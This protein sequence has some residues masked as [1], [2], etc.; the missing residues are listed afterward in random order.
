VRRVEAWLFAPG[1]PRVPAALR[2]GLS[3][4]LAVRLAR[5][6]YLHLAGQPRAL[7]RPLSFMHLIGS[8]PGRTVVLV[9]Q[10]AGVAAAVLAA[11][12]LRARATLPVAW[13]CG[14]LLNGMATSVGKVVHNDALLLLC[15][16]P[17]LPAT[18][19][20]AWSLDRVLLRRS[21]RLEAPAT[22]NPSVAY[23][24]P[25]RTA[26]VVAA[27]G[28]F[29]AG[30]AK[31]VF[32]GPAWVTSG[33]LRWVLYAASDARAV[34]NAAALFV[35]DRPWL[36]HLVAAATI[37]VELGFPLVLWKLRA[38]LFFVPAAIV[39]HVGIQVTL[40]LDYTAWIGT[41]AVVFTP[42]PAIANCLGQVRSQ[43]GP[44]SGK[45]H[46]PAAANAPP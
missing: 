6:L 38:A 30:L 37:V 29:F 41:I 17:L 24:W 7:Y 20:D 25:V 32:S 10:V 22:P 27:G 15:L 8:M 4:L 2:I 45:A 40:G 26:M 18:A 34:P 44:R 13:A 11:V 36:A 14:L 1:D 39:L 42:W 16:V 35:A 12:G 43:Y 33:T 9:A 3:G 31:L 21:A 19:S 23:G 46:R 28:Y 5:G